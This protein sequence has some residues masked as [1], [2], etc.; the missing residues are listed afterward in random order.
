MNVIIK[1]SSYLLFLITLSIITKAQLPFNTDTLH[2]KTIAAGP[3]YAKNSFY[4]WLWGSNYRKE[5]TVPVSYP[6]LILDTVKGGLLSF[7]EGGSNQ[8]KSLH[9]KTAGNKEYALRSVD[10][11]LTK[12][13]PPIFRNTFLASIINDEISMSH[14]YGALGVPIMADAVHIKHSI[15]V[16]YYLPA[17]SS[18]DTLNKKYAGK[19]YLFEQRASG[20]W[21]EADNLGNYSKFTDTDGMLEKIFG[22]NRSAVDQHEF[23]RARLFDMLIADFDRHAD[24]WKW[25]IKKNDSATVFDPIPT[26]RD[27]AFFKHNG[28]LLN[29]VISASG[30]KFLQS[31]DYRI[32]NVKAYAFV[33]RILDRLLT[34]KMALSEW[35]AIATDIQS[36][37]TDPIIEASVKQMPAEVFS[38][39]GNEIIEKMKSRRAHLVEYAREYYLL[40]AKEAEI[41]GTKENEYFQI[42]QRPNNVTA[43]NVFRRNK[44]DQTEGAPFYTRVFDPT[45]TKEIR[46]YGL[47]G[48]D[49]FSITGQENDKI[50]LRLIGGDMRDSIINNGKTPVEVY[51][52]ADNYF[53][54]NSAN[55][56]HLSN[57][58]AIHLFNYNS[59]KQDKKGFGPHIG[60]NDDDRI[61]VGI[62]YTMLNH[63]WRHPPFSSKQ[64]FD[65]DLSVI[66][67]AFS[68]TYN[69]LFPSLIGKWDLVTR[70][71]YDKVKW[72]NF[73]GLGNETPRVSGSTNYYRMRTENESASLGIRRIFGKNNLGISGFYERVAIHKDPERFVAKVL[74]PGNLGLYKA[75]N[76]AGVQAAYQF[77]HVK[78][79]ILPEQGITFLLSAKHTQNF[80]EKD[81]SFQRY[82]GIL[83]FFIPIVP[84]LSVAFKNGISTVTGTPLFYQYPSLG[85]TYNLRGFSRERFSGKTSFYNNT[86]LRYIGNIRSYIFNG[87]AGIMAFRDM[88][89]VWMPGE[90]SNTIHTA[91][92]GGLLLAP[93]NKISAAVTYGISNEQKILQ[94]RVGF[95]F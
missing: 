39:S 69:G 54:V 88:G 59:F 33:N 22:D 20:D 36:L 63:K 48:H 13:I 1:R 14:P 15:P 23:A 8:S 4:Q 92:G 73:F 51:D 94:F 79:S 11:T 35:E 74:L 95:L 2:Y 76:F 53:S 10:K 78:D 72:T 50:R 29:A 12:V 43:V 84:K 37:L 27:Q 86:E 93:F 31:Y 83:Q 55:H 90:K 81:K 58:S 66:Q 40:L 3:G 9:L 89:R 75:E 46:I 68:A 80:N 30:M 44:Q 71:N 25:G 82:G 77:V 45:E 16:Y 57:D 60:F 85:E 5:W 19:V 64:T 56:L 47:S 7:K 32:H 18:L 21:Q 61:F 26:D 34:N 87:K 17:Q 67:R 42:E 65:A 38:I 91:Y 41:V 6:I 49:I 52:N 62:R 24:Q 28:V 70:A